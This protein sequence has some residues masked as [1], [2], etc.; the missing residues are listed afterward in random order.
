MPDRHPQIAQAERR[1]H[2]RYSVEIPVILQPEDSP[3]PISS[4]ITTLSL[5]GCSLKLTDQFH[6]G[7]RL[8]I[9]L[10]LPG[11]NVVTIGRVIT[12][13][14]QFGNGIMFLKFGEDGEQQLRKFLEG[15]DP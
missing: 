6:V 1:L 11:R 7:Q 12:R 8:R 14:P 10:S 3:A 15:L 9:E 5:S 4:H 2:Q 13:H